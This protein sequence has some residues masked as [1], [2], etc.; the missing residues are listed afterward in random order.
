M[1]TDAATSIAKNTTVMM[2]SQMITWGSSFVLMLFLPRYLGSADY[3]R[4]YVA[5]S[6][7][8][9]FQILIEFG[10]PYYVAKE[11]AR[12]S[13]NAP[14][15]VVN[16]IVL[17]SC[18]W[19]FSLLAM[20]V[21]TIVAKYSPTVTALILILG[22]AKLWEGIGRLMQSCFQGLEK[23]QYQAA[24]AITER[25]FVTVTGVAALLLGGNSVVIAVLMAISTLLNASVLGKYMRRFIPRLPRPSVSEARRLLKAGTPYFLQTVFAI[26][27]YRVDAVM[28]SLMVPENVVGWYGA[29]YKFLD[30]LM[31]LPAIF[32]AAV[33]PVL[34]RLH[35]DSSNDHATVASKSLN[36]LIVTGIPL[37]I[38]VFAFSQEIIHLF[39]GVGEYEPSILLLQIFSVG[40]ILVYI[41]FILGAA[42]FASDRQR[43]WTIVALCA[44]FINPLL[45]YFMI[46]FAQMNFANGGIGAA[47]ATLITEFFV[48]TMGL[49]LM[50]KNLLDQ[51]HL[52]V[53][54]KAIISGCIMAVALFIVRRADVPWIIQMCLGS[55]VYIG[56]LFSLKAFSVS[57]ITFLREFFTV[58]NLRSI[59][60][61]GKR[62]SA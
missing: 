25:V 58:Q 61:L 35:S 7:T 15:L 46:P 60:A 59:F 53:Q 45:N 10:G 12:V 54:L 19:A 47:L 50:P 41:D 55:G 26:I 13:E 2:T 28:L 36:F 1:K 52:S 4:L 14:P 56:S 44:V 39:F 23:M 43:Q 57:E 32:S 6:L 3:G 38:G 42:L 48:M 22:V 51:G 11:V 5:I 37:S 49:L 30:V 20:I 34:S 16:T 8:M 27:Y 40:M 33:F 62:R 21:I 29:A 18:I 9:I 24:G 17:R 31:F